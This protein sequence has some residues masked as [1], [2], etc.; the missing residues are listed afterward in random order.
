MS[1]DQI[2]VDTLSPRQKSQLRW[3]AVEGFNAIH[4]LIPMARRLGIALIATMDSRSGQCFPSELFLAT[5][6]D[7]HLVSIKKAKVQLRELGLINW[8]KP[9]GPRHVSH[10]IFNWEVLCQCAVAANINAKKAVHESRLSRYKS[11]AAA[12]ND[13]WGMNVAPGAKDDRFTVAIIHEPSSLNPIEGS[14]QAF[15][16]VVPELSD[17]T[18]ITAQSYNLLHSQHEDTSV[19]ALDLTNPFPMAV[20]AQTTADIEQEA[21]LKGRCHFPKLADSFQNETEI[22]EFIHQLP[23]DL[24]DEAAKTLAEKNKIAARKVIMKHFGVQ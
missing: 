20:T 4:G 3:Q 16:K 14:G 8:T 6:L 5:K 23:F 2:S 7:V 22:W 17:I 15:S 18:H 21:R 13:R 9:G 1:V 11:N 19:A 10:Y 24:Q 12:I